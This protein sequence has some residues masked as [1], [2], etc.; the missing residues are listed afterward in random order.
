MDPIQERAARWGIESEYHDAFGRLRVVEAET[1]NR[2]QQLLSR[3]GEPP[4][5]RVPATVVIRRGQEA[6]V[7][8]QAPPGTPANWTIDGVET[9]A[10]GIGEAPVIRLPAGLPVGSYM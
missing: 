6:S 2:L 8:L 3:D 7:T 1:L 10:Q 4:Q 5:R 9:I